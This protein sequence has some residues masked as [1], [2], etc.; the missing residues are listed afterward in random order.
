MTNIL[1]TSNWTNLWNSV[2]FS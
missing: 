2:V 1:T